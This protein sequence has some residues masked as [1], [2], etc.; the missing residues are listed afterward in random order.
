MVYV[1]DRAN[2]RIQVY[3][4]DGKYI[5]QVFINR[6][7]PNG[8]SGAGIAFSP[9]K[10]QQYMYV[11]DYGNSRIVVLDRKSLQELYQFGER[12]AKPGDFQGIHHIAVDSKGNIY[13]GEV[14]PG[15][16]VQK[17]TFKGFSAD[18]PPSALTG[19]QL[20]GQM[21]AARAAIAA[22]RGGG[23]RGPAPVS[24]AIFDEWTAAQL[25]TP[26][27]LANY[28][29]HNASVQH[30]DP[31]SPPEIHPGFSHV[32]IFTSGSGTFIVGGQIVDGPNGTK[33]IQ[34][35]ESHKIVLGEVWHI[36][37][38][39]AHQVVADPGG[40][41]VNYFITNVNIPPPPAGAPAP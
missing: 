27:N 5:T 30:R 31:G 12:S 19:E 11:A 7:G 8:Q 1:A 28:G 23:G 24:T 6:E 13:A 26:A 3:T 2:R 29:N 14:A 15:A 40:P 10:A 39:I 35:G 20:A 9:D 36:P 37:A 33:T 21:A 32:L 18:L 4:I 38:S 41:G 17:F 34:G 22:A 16:R 25:A